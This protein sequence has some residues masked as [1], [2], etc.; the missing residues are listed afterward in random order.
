MDRDE[1]A[2]LAAILEKNPKVSDAQIR[3][4]LSG[5]KCRCSTHMD[6]TLSRSRDSSSTSCGSDRSVPNDVPSA[7][8]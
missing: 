8:S 7:R 3:Q 1:V 5:V 4:Q 6:S 2:A